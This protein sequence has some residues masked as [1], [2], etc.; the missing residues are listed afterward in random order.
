MK[1]SFSSIAISTL[2]LL[3]VG[4][5]N[6]T[7]LAQNTT[8]EAPETMESVT[9]EATP[10]DTHAHDH[11]APTKGGQV[12]ETGAYHLEFVA[13]PEPGGTHL[14]FYLQSGDSHET[15]PGATVM[16]QIQFPNGE[17]EV[18][19]LE[20][21]EAGEHY[22]AFL[23]GEQPGEYR[24]TVLSDIQGEKVNGRFNFQR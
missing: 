18:L 16:A 11:S 17:Q 24:V 5:N 7:P 4:C 2:A 8:P 22:A 15:I 6:S 23:P 10:T 21:D 19:D 12:V 9:I 13:L 14:D 1:K 3:F 20:Y